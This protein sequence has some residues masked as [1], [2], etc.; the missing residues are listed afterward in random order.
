MKKSDVALLVLIVALT[1]AIAFFAAGQLPFLKTDDRGVEVRTVEPI[2]AE[3]EHQPD[4]TVF[5]KDANPINPTVQT[6]IGEQ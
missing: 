1:A 6:V 2:S 5:G 4:A 3:V